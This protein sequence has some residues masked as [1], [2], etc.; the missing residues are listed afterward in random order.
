MRKNRLKS[1]SNVVAVGLVG[2][3]EHYFNHVLILAFDIKGPAH[4]NNENSYLL[5]PTQTKLIQS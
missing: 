2:Y 4:S 1:F 3:A 5:A